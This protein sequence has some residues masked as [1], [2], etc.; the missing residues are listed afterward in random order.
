MEWG[1]EAAERDKKGRAGFT[2]R[3]SR[4]PRTIKPFEMRI[5]RVRVLLPNNTRLRT[6]VHSS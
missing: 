3:L 4:Q 1:Q 2:A 6:E 5:F